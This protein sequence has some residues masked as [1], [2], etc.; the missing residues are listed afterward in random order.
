MFRIN[1]SENKSN[2]SQRKTKFVH[3]QKGEYGENKIDWTCTCNVHSI[4][5][6]ALY[7]GWVFPKS[8]FEREPDAFADYIVKECLKKD[9]WFKEKMPKLWENWY[10]GDPKAYTPLEL[11]A[12]LAHYFNNYLGCTN[13]DLFKE[14]ASIKE[15]I[16]QLYKNRIGVPTSVKWAGLNGHIICLVGFECSSEDDLITWLEGTSQ[17]N[18]ITKIIFDDPWGKYIESEDVYKVTESGNDC[19]ISFDTF[20]KCV[21]DIN[22]P[23]FKYAHILSKPVASV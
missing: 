21:K 22:N 17:S 14:T 13:A 6:A 12:V 20:K 18:P 4:V 9:N 8:S 1:I 16:N 23:N 11:H 10:K 15:I 5:M 2:Y 7:S 3:A 19:E